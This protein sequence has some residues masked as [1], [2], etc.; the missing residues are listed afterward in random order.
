MVFDTRIK[1]VA[2]ADLVADVGPV[3]LVE[4]LHLRKGGFAKILEIIIPNATDGEVIIIPKL[5]FVFGAVGG[6]GGIAGVNWVGF[7]ILIEE[8]G[9]T[10]FDEDVVFL[11][12]FLK[13]IFVFD[14][15]IFEGDTVGAD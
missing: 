11:D 4:S 15:S 9:K 3:I 2:E 8:V 12:V 1:F 5:A 10:N 13:L 6:D 14:D 7:S